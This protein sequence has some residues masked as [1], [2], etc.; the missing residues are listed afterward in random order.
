[1]HGVVMTLKDQFDIRGYDSTLG[2]V[3]RSFKPAK[4]D[5]L[6]VKILKKNGVVFIAKTNLPRSIMW[7]VQSIIRLR[8]VS[9]EWDRCETD[10]PLW[11]LT[12]H[13]TN[14]SLTPGGSSGGEAALLAQHGAV[15]GWV[16]SAMFSYQ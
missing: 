15:L 11:G 4:D 2:S 1:M 16:S 9:D 5:A 6:L 3:G 13:P 14:S 10:N 7:Q 8:I 12:T